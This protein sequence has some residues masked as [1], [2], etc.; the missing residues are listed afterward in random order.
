MTQKTQYRVEYNKLKQEWEVFSYVE[1][2]GKTFK[3][4]VG[5]DKTKVGAE[6]LIK[7]VSSR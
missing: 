2:M 1:Y 3:N 7:K 5:S 4:W 6:T